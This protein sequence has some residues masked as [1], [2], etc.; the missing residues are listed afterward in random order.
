MKK[1]VRT[2]DFYGFDDGCITKEGSNFIKNVNNS[3][4]TIS[5]DA[6]YRVVNWFGK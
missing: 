6:E 2:L 4:G 3:G 1:K 5:K